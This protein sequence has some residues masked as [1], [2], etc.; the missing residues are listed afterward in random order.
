MYLD[1]CAFSAM[2]ADFARKDDIDVGM[3]T[4]WRSGMVPLA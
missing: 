4:Q 2:V 1:R 3:M